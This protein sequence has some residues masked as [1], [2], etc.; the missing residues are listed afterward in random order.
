[1]KPNVTKQT[2]KLYW[3]H[4]SHYKIKSFFI[5]TMVVGAVI[6]GQF[7]VPLITANI[8]DTLTQ[9]N[10]SDLSLSKDFAPY[11]AIL[12]L[13]LL[14]ELVLWRVSIYLFWTMEAKIMKQLSERCFNFLM[15]Q[16]HRFH[17]NNF[18]G[19]LVS[20]SNKFVKA[21]ERILDETLF[22][23]ITIIASYFATIIILLPR[24]PQYVLVFT[25]VSLA[26]IFVL[27]WRT[28]KAHP[29]NVREATAES[30]Q[31]AQLADAIT[32]VETIKPFANENLENKLFE[33]KT[34]DVLNKSLATR[35]IVTFNEIIFNSFSASL[36]FIAI[37]F[38]IISVVVYGS[39]IGTV[40]LI[41]SYTS[42]LLR[43]FWELQQVMRTLTRGF[44]DAHDM[45]MLLQQTPEIQDTK[46]PV[47]F[48]SV[49]GDI[50]FSNVTYAY[51]E[52]LNKP[53]FKNLDLHIKPGEKIGLVGHSGGGKTT[54]TKL[55][56]RL[57]DINK[58][59]I[60]IDGF[61]ISKVKQESLRQ[62]IAYVPQ[63]PLM[64]HRTLSQ[65]IRYGQLDATEQEIIAAAKMAHA[66]EFIRGLH[67]GYDTLVGERGTK[68]SGGQR[69]R[70]AIA[71]AMLKNAPIIILDEATSALDSESEK[72][73]QDALWKLMEGKTT[74]IIAHRLSTI[75]KM[76]R[77]L[78]LENG[79][80][81]EQGTHK[82]L[83]R[84]EGPY[85]SLWQHQSGGFIEN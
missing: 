33:K 15:Y 44:G 82:E 72:L 3:Q 81:V 41:A 30:N 38:A 52:N 20:Q 51:P 22:S 13:L 69:Q 11:L 7:L 70:I 36:Y 67:K 10:I 39:S 12:A 5:T 19:S 55:I 21:F 61:D 84:K 45:T 18:G 17:S 1:M 47:E 73:I 16:T 8:L 34:K 9:N 43:R 65:N 78:V 25:I 35:N 71:R 58:G 66:D 57:M 62:K 64:F 85:A 53:L 79:E 42:N 49:R 28:K 4:L 60:S 83:I 54:I 2:I 29:Y 75:Q 24:A 74:I 40:V 48:N 6:S 76:D 27:F 56:L 46:N 63:E 31:T 80:I 26:Y 68:L 59:E 77:I 23:I 32:N 37:F 14:I 50:K